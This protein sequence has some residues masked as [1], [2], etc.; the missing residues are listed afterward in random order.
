[1]DRD[2]EPLIGFSP[3]L[4]PIKVPASRLQ[5]GALSTWEVPSSHARRSVYALVESSA[6]DPRDDSVQTWAIASGEV[7]VE[8]DVAQIAVQLPR[9]KLLGRSRGLLLA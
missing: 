4:A 2:R 3:V 1:G 9:S 6:P 8:H 5:P 7:V